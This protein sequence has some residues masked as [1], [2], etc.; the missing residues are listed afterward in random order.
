M[1]KSVLQSIHSYI[2]SVFLLPNKLVDAIEKMIYAFWW[3]NGGNLRRGLLW[4][5]WERLSVHKDFGGMGFKDL[6]SFNVAMLGIHGWRFQTDS[7]SLVSRLFKARYFP[8][9][10]FIGSNIGHNPCYVWRSIFGA[11]I[12]VKKGV[13][14]RI[15]SS[16]NIPFLGAHWLKGGLSLSTSNPIF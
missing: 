15:G 4:M 3:G 7:S 11:K 14:W 9:S 10:D 6:T 12:V 13:R 5:S 16:V 1:I 2:M 8:N